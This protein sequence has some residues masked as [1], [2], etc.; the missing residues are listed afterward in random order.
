MTQARGGV[1]VPTASGWVPAPPDWTPPPAW[2]PSPHGWVPAPAGWQPPPGWVWT[3]SGYLPPP[4]TPPLARPSGPNAAARAFG[5]PLVLP[6]PPQAAAAAADRRPAGIE[7]WLVLLLFPATAV[8]SAIAVLA[9]TITHTKSDACYVHAVIPD[10]PWVSAVLAAAA[11][12]LE[13]GPALLVIYLLRLSGGGV[14]AI[15]LDLRHPRADLARCGKLLVLAYIIGFSIAGIITS[16]LHIGNPVADTIPP[17]AAYLLPLL[18][19]AVG[20]GVVEEIIVLGYLVHRLEQ[21]GWSGWRLVAVCTVV[22][23][24]Y[25]LYYGFGAIGIAGWG[26][27][28]VVLYRRRRRLLTFIVLHLLWDGVQFIAIYLK[29]GVRVLPFLALI[30][31]V[32]VLWGVGRNPAVEEMRASRAV[33]DAD[34]SAAQLPA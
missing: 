2:L 20:A 33:R 5:W 13:L 3:P 29:G 28:S 31:G 14:R 22:R 1:Y 30:V 4:P 23:T 6:R 27:M 7:I 18:I 10:K 17:S 21:R 9:Q 26:A 16:A 19:S 34:P 25:H 12:V 32:L 24:S 8:V 11:A 15:G